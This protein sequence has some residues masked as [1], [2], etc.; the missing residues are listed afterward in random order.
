MKQYLLLFFIAIAFFSCKK[1]D[2]PTSRQDTLRSGNWNRTSMKVT[3]HLTPGHDTTQDVLPL[4]P[5]CKKDDYLVFKANLD[6]AVNS[7]SSK[8]ASTDPSE[9]PFTWEVVNGGN[10]LYIYNATD[11]FGT[12]SVLGDIVVLTDNTLGLRYD[13]YYT[14]SPGVI[15]TFH[16][17]CT[18]SK[19]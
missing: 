10:N 16:Y 1:A 5:S 6:G 8:C 13:M 2:E 14:M 17:A 19:F 11:F 18:F 15:D 4:L 7:G 3:Y 12:Q 9:V